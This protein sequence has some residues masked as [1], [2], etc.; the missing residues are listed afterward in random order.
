MAAEI[1]LTNLI[2]SAS[3]EPLRRL[4]EGASYMKLTF[5]CCPVGGSFDILV[6]TLDP[7]FNEADVTG[8][9]LMIMA[10]E[11]RRHGEPRA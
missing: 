10:G 7:D 8:M 11:I 9:V 6:G 2:A 1:K 4:L 5:K 3:A